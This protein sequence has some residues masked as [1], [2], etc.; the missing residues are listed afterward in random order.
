MQTNTNLRV[1]ENNS[2]AT[3]DF[4][5]QASGKMFHMVISGLY[6]NKPQSITREIWSNA[7]DAHAMVGKQNVPFEVTFPTPLTPVFS[8]RDFGPG[9]AHEDMEGFYTVLGHSTKENTNKAVGKWGVGRM[10]PMSYTDTFSVVSRHKGLI[11]YYSIQLGPDG[12]PQL[13]VLAE[14]SPTNEPDGLEVSFP[15]KRDDIPSFQRAAEVVSYGFKVQPHVK[16]SRDK[17]FQ[18]IK[19]LIEGEGYY[20]YTDSRL[21]GPYAQ[22]GCVLYPINTSSLPMGLLSFNTRNVVFEFDIGDLEVTASRED[23]SYG[24][25]DPTL[26]NIKKV[27]S[28][29]K[30]GVVEKAQAEI[31]KEPSLYRATKAAYKYNKTLGNNNFCWR[32][33]PIRDFQPDLKYPSL[34]IHV[35]SKGYRDKSTVGFGTETEASPHLD[36]TIYVQDVSDKVANVRATKRISS[37]LKPHERLIWV[38]VDLS[39]T[40]AK[41]SLATMIHDLDYPVKYI[42][43]LADNG[44]VKT[45]PR[46]KLSVSYL[47]NGYD[48]RRS[49]EMDDVM[50]QKGG[51]YYP[52]EGGLY[53]HYLLSL[54]P[55]VKSE[56][57]QD[58]ILVP[59]P[60]WKKF[61]S[62]PQWHLIVPQLDKMIKAKAQLAQHTLGNSYHYY[63]YLRLRP[64]DA[65]AGIVGDFAK[66]LNGTKQS[67]Y[68]GLTRSVWDSNLKRLELPLIH[69]EK[70]SQE[71]KEVID[72]YPLL[73][74]DVSLERNA[75]HFLH[76]INLI[77]NA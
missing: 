45:G 32:G 72:K 18:P 47:C 39:S 73:G 29:V 7:F 61:E 68:L 74:L 30:E 3:K 55:M 76:Y 54:I 19:K 49:M 14:P 11:A 24:A 60:M 8:C 46:A 25:N 38:K 43:D 50:F 56:L 67:E 17:Q 13:H 59:K 20:F 36:Y 15:V 64:F 62:A 58:I 10:S 57:L 31:D 52:M 53:P 6:S 26:G 37:D 2:H 63:P 48:A 1:V 21:S 34:S 69:D 35:G 42:K 65:A 77:N 66:R 71:Y 51:F 23:L 28:K 27:I 16:N 75:K 22:M 5:I 33:T 4:T 41:T 12:S 70:V 44:P 9:I 40:L